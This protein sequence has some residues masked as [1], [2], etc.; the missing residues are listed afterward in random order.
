MCGLQAADIGVGISGEEGMQAVNSA[1]YSIAQASLGMSYFL[2][3]CSDSPL[4]SI[5]EE[6][7][8]CSWTLVV[9]SKRSHVC[10]RRFQTRIC[11]Y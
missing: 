1:D 4:V 10:L 9:R 5:P 6:T 7:A 8:A 3:C 11:K 2:Y